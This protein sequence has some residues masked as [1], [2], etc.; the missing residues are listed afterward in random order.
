[1]IFIGFVNYNK[2]Y[3]KIATVLPPLNGLLQIVPSNE[4]LTHHI[5]KWLSMSGFIGVVLSH[6]IKE[7]SERSIAFASFSLITAENNYAQIDRKY[8]I[9]FGD[10]NG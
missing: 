3:P 7:S 5:P 4:V 10:L 8:W 9:W 6:A 1:M 2:I